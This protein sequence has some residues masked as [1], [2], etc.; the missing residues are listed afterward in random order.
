MVGLS[1]RYVFWLIGTFAFVLQLILQVSSGVVASY[2]DQEFGL[3]P[4]YSSILV[5][6]IFY[7]HILMQ[8]PAG[9]ILERYGPRR[10]LGV[11]G[12]ISCIGAYL[13]SISGTFE[14]ALLSR[15][16]MG[17]G[18][19]CAFIAL[20]AI[21]GR[22]FPIYQ[23]AMMIAL[24]E[25]IGLF[26][27]AVSEQV[28]PGFFANYSWRTFYQYTGLSALLLA[29][30]VWVFMP[31]HDRAG[32]VVS[33][34]QGVDQVGR[35]VS[36]RLL[37]LNGLHSGMLFAVI[38]GFIAGDALQM[39]GAMADVTHDDAGIFCASTLYGVVFGA[40]WVSYICLRYNLKEIIFAMI[41]MPL[42]SAITLIAF[43]WLPEGVYWLRVIAGLFVGFFSSGYL[44]SFR[45]ASDYLAGGEGKS[46]LMGF[47]N[48]LSVL[49]GP[50][51]MIIAGMLQ[52]LILQ[53]LSMNVLVE[54]VPL[55]IYQ[56]T[57]SFF[58]VLLM[59]GG[60][61]AWRLLISEQDKS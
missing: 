53:Y 58:V 3:G 27:A 34:K 23:F 22:W 5:S 32:R 40:G 44:L 1:I 4:L 13:F 54:E 12:V 11:G 17:S 39:F 14:M 31:D 61:L 51:A 59:M 15:I 45:F 48:M 47:T 6:S 46:I 52:R 9:V 43:I 25:M 50:V 7:L 57:C 8:I 2:L 30:V 55:W 19:S 28:L 56:S 33:L 18:L 42:L 21:V 38:T 24:A 36:I 41:W 26:V 37:W 20:A 49:V 60:F 10:V 16:F 29:I 35:F